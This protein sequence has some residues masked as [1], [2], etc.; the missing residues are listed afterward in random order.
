MRKEANTSGDAAELRR[1]AEARLPERH[2]NRAPPRTDADTQR[3]VHEL[4]VHQ[5]ELEMQ[6]AELQGARDQM[7]AMLEKYTDLYDFA[8]VGYFSIDDQCLILDVNLTAAALL[9]VERSQLIHRRLPHFLAPTTRPI[10]LAFL[11]KVFTEPGRQ[12]CEASLLYEES[13]PFWANVQAAS[14]TSLHGERKWCRMAVSD[15]TALKRAEAAMHKLTATLESRVAQRTAELEHRTRQL[16]KLALELLQAEDRERKRLADILHDDLQQQL[17]AAKFHLSLL[18]HR[19]S[20]DASLREEIDQVSVLIKDAIAKSRS[21]S[22]ELG[23]AILYHGDFG[24]ALEW[25]ADQ[26]QAKHGLAVHVEIH[27]PV[28][29]SS[30]SIKVLLFRTT[31]EILFNIVKHAQVTEAAVRLRQRHGQLWLTICDHGRGFDPKTL[32]QTGGSGLL[33]IRER[34]ELLGGRMKIRSAP[35]RGSTFGIAVPD[36]DPSVTVV[37]LGPVGEEEALHARAGKPAKR[38]E[39][40]RKSAQTGAIA[41]KRVEKGDGHLSGSRRT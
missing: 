32:G 19:I 17:A 36:G 33:S 3:L 22:H 16:Q 12:V 29:G 5:I 18:G 31:Q 7:E 9:G 25:L 24:E 40:R 6:N 27:D 2:K 15:I 41:C 39:K 26:I 21:L 20:G 34:V 23:P 1:R 28:D 11:E 30:D 38:D 13:T 37:A 4:Q 8:P 10:F 14:A 35:G